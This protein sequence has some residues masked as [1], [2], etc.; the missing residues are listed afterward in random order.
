MIW[1][2]SFI[3]SVFL[4]TVVPFP[5]AFADTGPVKGIY[6]LMKA[7]KPVDSLVSKITFLTGLSIRA[8]WKGL[9]PEEGKFD[10]SYLDGAIDDAR[11]AGKKAML[12]VLPGYFSP[13]WLNKKGVRFIE[14]KDEN[15]YRSTY[16]EPV[17]IPLPWDEA[18]L[19]E[20][21]KFVVQLGARYSRYSELVLVHMAGPT[22]F[23][24][25]MHLPKFSQESRQVVEAAGYSKNNI[26]NAWE[27]VIDAFA[28]AFPDK[29]LAL[30][31]AIPF[32]RDGALEDILQYASAKL[33]KRLCAQDN[34]LSDHH[35]D[36]ASYELVQTLGRQGVNIGFQ[37]LDSATDRPDR[38]G[39]LSVSIEQGLMAG[40]QYFEIYQSD[41]LQPQNSSL[42][43]E[44]DKKL[45]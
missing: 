9:E 33:G 28:E 40:A 20:W 17:R 29:S 13:D 39:S 27:K 23:S 34:Q 31:L 24:G 43:E 3:L 15:I 18:Y 16:G 26:V 4:A 12:R 10:W 45:R 35:D 32:R 42:F 2:R 6:C 37:M 5:A 14:L 25:E 30:N 11:K 21:V 41:L 7:M 19:N 8:H 22:C 38:Q 44:L 36:S 1:A